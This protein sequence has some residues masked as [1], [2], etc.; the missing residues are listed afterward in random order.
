[1]G[2]Q[3]ISKV[4]FFQIFQTFWDK[5]RSFHGGA[6]TSA[7]CTPHQKLRHRVSESK[8][9]T[10]MIVDRLNFKSMAL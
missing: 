6:H 7:K 2:V 4:D 3:E 8:N 9:S 10:T 1:M 5:T